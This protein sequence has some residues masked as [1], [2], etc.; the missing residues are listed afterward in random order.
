M[1]GLPQRFPS[2]L[3]GGNF[4][5]ALE[6]VRGVWPLL[7]SCKTPI[8]ISIP[9]PNTTRNPSL[10]RY[11]PDVAR[12]PDDFVSVA[13]TEIQLIVMKERVENFDRLVDVVTPFLRSI[14]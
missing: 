1:I 8:D 11:D 9:K 7:P 13:T 4:G 2:T 5:P 12:R 3:T 6:F 14:A 10:I